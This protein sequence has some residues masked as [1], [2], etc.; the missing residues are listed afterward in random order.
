MAGLESLSG[1]VVAF[2][3][4]FDDRGDV[5]PDRIR[6]NV[7]FLVQGGVT[8]F[9]ACGGT[10]LGAVLTIE[11]RERVTETLLDVTGSDVPVL[12]HAGAPVTRD[13]I[14]LTEH[15]SEKGATAVVLSSPDGYYRHEP[16]AVKEHFELIC[17]S[18][19]GM[20]FY[21]YR[22]PTDTWTAQLVNE[23]KE[24]YPNLA[25]IKDSATDINLHLQFLD[26]GLDLFQGYEPLA[27]ASILAGDKGLIS[28]L[29]TIFPEPVAKLYQLLTSGDLEAARSQQAF[30]NKLVMT[31][32]RPAPYRRFKAVLR[33]RGY[34][35]GEV[36]RPFRPI[37]KREESDLLE[38]LVRLGALDERAEG[39]R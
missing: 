30:V 7:D 38:R 14:R 26:T 21:L 25:G 27:T 11:E 29:A 5:S 32:Y 34:P 10:G 33:A 19:Q 18:L 12:V 3:T 16:E 6:R 1:V 28:G 13:S 17:E 20:P 15:A 39:V 37:S 9:F 4:P 24:S 8:G 2:D 23:L 22:R 35:S 36:R 31:T